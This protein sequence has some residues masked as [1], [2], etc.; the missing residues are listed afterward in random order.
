MP[1]WL[2]FFEALEWRRDVAQEALETV[3]WRPMEGKGKGA[4]NAPTRTART[5]RSALNVVWCHF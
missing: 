2:I 5:P 4:R 3:G 1:R